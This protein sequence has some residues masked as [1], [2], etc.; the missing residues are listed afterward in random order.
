MGTYSCT[1]E[2]N[3]RPH[4][5]HHRREEKHTKSAVLSIIRNDKWLPGN[6]RRIPMEVRLGGWDKLPTILIR[7]EFNKRKKGKYLPRYAWLH[8]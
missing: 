7:E 4:P 1:T 8:L 6:Y 3:T 2:K 5:T